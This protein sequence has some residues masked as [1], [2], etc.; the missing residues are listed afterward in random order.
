M[1]SQSA[2]AIGMQARSFKD[3][4][5]RFS[6]KLPI[7]L[8]MILIPAAVF[9]LYVGAF[10]QPTDNAKDTSVMLVN[11]DTGALG[12]Q[13]ENA[14]MESGAF[15][16]RTAT[17]DYARQ[18]IADGREWAAVV[19]PPDYSEK[20]EGGQ[21]SE[22]WLIVDDQQSYI[23]TRVLY[24]TFTVVAQ[25]VNEQVQASYLEQ[26][27]SGLGSAATQEELTQLQLVE[28]SSASQQLAVGTGQAAAYTKT[29]SQ[30]SGE[31]AASTGQ[32]ARGM[33]DAGMAADSLRAGLVTATSGANSLTENLATL[34]NGSAQ[35]KGAHQMLNGTLGAAMQAAQALPNSTAQATIIAALTGAQFISS[36]EYA[37][38]VSID[39]G[40][41]QLYDGSGQ[42]ASGLQTATNGAGSLEESLLFAYR[43]GKAA[44][45]GIY[46]TSDSLNTLS[47]GEETLSSGQGQVAAGT[48]LLAYKEGKMAGA[49]SSASQAAASP[50]GV[51]LVLK[52]ANKTNYGTFFATA[53][54][55]L[56]LF[57]GA[58]SAYVYAALNM[59]KRALPFAALFC[60]AQVLVLLGA[61]LYMG[62]P[63][64]EGIEAL[65]AVMIV[66]SATFLMMTRAIAYL[67][68]DIFTSE[69]LQIMSPVLSLLAVFMISS[70]GA[71][72]PQHTLN[73]PF[74]SFT[75]YIPFYYATMGVRETALGASFPLYQMEMLAAFCLAFYIIRRLAERYRRVKRAKLEKAA[76]Q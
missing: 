13:T 64:R 72:W 2:G 54:I 45:S 11:L 19:I 34:K 74:S 52:E 43:G 6:D 66:I 38:I 57:F 53:F 39:S 62:F 50:P 8:A 12:A 60:L 17:Y 35:V 21:K 1:L 46:D 61:Y 51:E 68:G 16:F 4:A 32:L 15:K 56:G 47:G 14:I 55:V 10:Y 9:V 69:H 37:G 42:L 24:P 48:G 58:A 5:E 22:L 40:A 76:S 65:F 63:A 75:P 33:W 73:A 28:V 27:G 44:A 26:M 29:A 25:K 3:D 71:L 59:V 20:L 31:I 18:S 36:Q 41:Q 67:M 7:I 23:I 70:G 30:Y 49:L